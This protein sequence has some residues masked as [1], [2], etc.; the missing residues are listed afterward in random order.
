ML[1]D[2]KGTDCNVD[3]EA[4]AIALSKN[5]IEDFVGKVEGAF[6][7]VW[8]DRKESKLHFIRNT[9]RPLHFGIIDN[10]ESTILFASE[11]EALYFVAQRNNLKLSKIFSLNEG[12]LLT[13]DKE[14]N[15]TIKKVYDGKKVMPTYIARYRHPYED[16]GSCT[17]YQYNKPTRVSDLFPEEETNN[18]FAA[19]GMEKNDEVEF[20]YNYFEPYNSN[21]QR[22][23]LVG[24]QKYY[25]NRVVKVHNYCKSQLPETKGTILSGELIS[26]SKNKKSNAWRDKY[27][28]IL[29]DNSI[30]EFT[31]ENYYDDE[32]DDL[33]FD[34]DEIYATSKYLA[35]GKYVSEEKFK[36]LTESGCEVCSC[37]INS[38]DDSRI[39]WT[40]SNRPVCYDCSKSG[41]YDSY[42]ADTP[43]HS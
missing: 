8:Y 18:P 23:C 36:K 21:S 14:N 12:S 16:Y 1:A 6:A 29:R 3:S 27:T 35:N 30:V 7:I 4:L 37:P 13:F 10:D 11:A 42:I 20:L 9:E 33:Y 22:G 25:P 28:L 41:E 34:S 17:P 40:N 15:Y 39:K 19:I 32:D 26:L 2:K 5:S 43:I 24:E 38:V 31:N